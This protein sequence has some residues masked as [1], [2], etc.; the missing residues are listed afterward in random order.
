MTAELD[1]ADDEV[2][3]SRRLGVGDQHSDEKEKGIN[4]PLFPFFGIY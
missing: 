1:V 4:I 3:C 2:P